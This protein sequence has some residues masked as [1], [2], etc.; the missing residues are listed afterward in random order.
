MTVNNECQNS[1]PVQRSSAGSTTAPAFSDI[2]SSPRRVGIASSA[3]DKHLAMESSIVY[4]QLK[5]RHCVSDINGTCSIATTTNASS[6]PINYAHPF[7]GQM[8]HQLTHLICH[9]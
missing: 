7:H 8:L 5:Y 9:V 4:M 3:Q 6:S 2:P 1:Q